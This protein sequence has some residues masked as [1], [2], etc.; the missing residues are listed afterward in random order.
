MVD[1]HTVQNRRVQIMSRD[2]IL[3]DVVGE[4]T[5]VAVGDPWLDATPGK[6]DGKAAGVV[7][8]TIL[9]RSQFT[10]TVNGPSKFTTPDNQCLIQQSA[11]L[12]SFRSAAWG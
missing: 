9:L 4:L 5:T 3:S 12:K 6:P 1:S 8:A 11:T 10:L 2:G 7:V